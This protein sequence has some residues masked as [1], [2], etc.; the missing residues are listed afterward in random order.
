MGLGIR[1]VPGSWERHEC[2][3]LPKGVT[4]VRMPALGW[5][6]MHERRGRCEVVADGFKFCPWCGGKLP[7][8]PT[9]W[10]TL[11]QVVG[12]FGCSTG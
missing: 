10:Q 6:V 9:P 5:C 8:T 2:A 3:A 12:G 7:E 4:L 1:D 11:K